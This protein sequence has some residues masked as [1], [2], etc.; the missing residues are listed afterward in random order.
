MTTR[1]AALGRTTRLPAATS[2]ALSHSLAPGNRCGACQQGITRLMPPP[3]NAPQQPRC[4]VPDRASSP[5]RLLRGR[6]EI[7]CSGLLRAVV[8]RVVV[9]VAADALHRDARHDS[10]QHPGPHL[11]EVL[12]RALCGLPLR[13]ADLHGEQYAGN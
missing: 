3:H 10:P 9:E 4:R 6:P 7:P 13:D 5:P 1:R 8:A 11:L 2:S 12:A